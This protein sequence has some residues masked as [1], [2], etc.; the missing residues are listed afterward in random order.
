MASRQV[1]LL[2]YRSAVRSEPCESHQS[3]LRPFQR[4]SGNRSRIYGAGV[5]AQARNGSVIEVEG[6]RMLALVPWA[7]SLNHCS[8]ATERSV[9][10]YDHAN[11]SAVLFA[12]KDYAEGEEVF[13]SYGTWLTP[14]ELLLD[15]GFV[16]GPSKTNAITVCSP[17]ALNCC[18]CGLN[19]VT[20]VETCWGRCAVSTEMLG[21]QCGMHIGL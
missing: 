19:S 13:D 7:D 5:A 17:M 11:D 10:Q 14:S 9:L 20:D 8:T 1:L 12:H 2:W 3:Q 4:A 18:P 21:R 15:Y 16:A 6:E